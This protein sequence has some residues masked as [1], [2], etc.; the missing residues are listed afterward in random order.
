MRIKSR[1][2]L[3]NSDIKKIT[4]ELQVIFGAEI[5]ELFRGN[6]EIAETDE[7]Y[8][9]ILQNGEPVM[10]FVDGRP[11]PTVRGALKL[12]TKKRSVIIDGGAVKFIAKG[13]DVMC[14][15]IINADQEIQRGDLVIVMDEVHGKAL[16]IGKALLSGEEMTGEKG[17][18]VKSLHYVGDRIWSVKV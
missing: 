18:A 12:R 5:E 17:R 6:L 15:G 13:A 3:K 9:L 8:N 11:F 16:A 7:R 2:F 1:H 14:P 10:F 4:D